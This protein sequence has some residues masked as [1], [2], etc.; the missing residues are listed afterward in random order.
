MQRDLQEGEGIL[1]SGNR[2]DEGMGAGRRKSPRLVNEEA[3]GF[4]EKG[5]FRGDQL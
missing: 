3:G 2:M 5:G 1:G 4:G